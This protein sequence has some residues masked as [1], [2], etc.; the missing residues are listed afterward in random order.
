VV[1]FAVQQFLA[2]NKVKKES[3]EQFKE[4]AKEVKQEEAAAADTSDI[5]SDISTSEN[6]WDS[7]SEGNASEKA[8]DH[9]PEDNNG[10]FS[11][12]DESGDE[13]CSQKVECKLKM[14]NSFPHFEA[15]ADNPQRRRHSEPSILQHNGVPFSSSEKSGDEQAEVRQDSGH[16]PSGHPQDIENSGDLPETPAALACDTPEELFYPEID[17]TFWVDLPQTPAALACDTPEE[18]FYPEIDHTFWVSLEAQLR[19]KLEALPN[20]TE[21]HPTAKESTEPPK[22]EHGAK[23]VGMPKA[24]DKD[25]AKSAEVAEKTKAEAGTQHADAVP[26]LKEKNA[27][28]AEVQPEHAIESKKLGNEEQKEPISPSERQ[29]Q[30]EVDEKD[31]QKKEQARCQA[32]KLAKTK[33]ESSAKAKAEQTMQEAL[34]F[35]ALEQKWQYKDREGNVH[36]SFPTENMQPVK[37]TYAEIVMKQ[38]KKDLEE[39]GQARQAEKTKAEAG[40]QHADAVPALKEKNAASAE[41]QPEH[42]IESK[43]LGN[44]E[45]KEPI[46]PSERQRQKEVDEKDR[47]KQEQARCQAQKAE[48]T[49]AE[50]SAKAK[51]EQTMQEALSFKALE[52]KWQYKDRKGKIQGPFPRE[53]M[54]QWYE[55]LVS[56]KKRQWYENGLLKD[57]LFH[58]QLRSMLCIGRTIA[59]SE[60]SPLHKLFPQV[61]DAFNVTVQPNFPK[62]WNIVSKGNVLQ[63]DFSEEEILNVL[64]LENE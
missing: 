6:G 61:R 15:K 23:S 26:A 20:S 29:R 5:S 9:A 8:S 30:K 35:E 55:L 59:V 12:S 3:E 63:R 62:V 33:A 36:G 52:Q 24:E 42:A 31:R 48:K 25:E 64:Y 50:S 21:D 47:Q 13:H 60:F 10:L 43:K 18:L 54:R 45:Q 44:E 32:Q 40:T 27:A 19:A 34:S 4:N 1:I 38:H 39:K 11:S 37:R 56:E 7:A 14:K 53:K 57:D 16:D 58:L 46:S 2:I 28:S 41:V 22:A 51:A 17:P 49:K